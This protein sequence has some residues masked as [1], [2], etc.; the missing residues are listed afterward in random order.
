MQASLWEGAGKSLP[1]RGRWQEKPDGGSRGGFH[2]RPIHDDNCVEMVWHK[3]VLR[4]IKHLPQSPTGDSSLWEG[5]EKSLPR[6]GRWQAKPDGGS[7]GGFHIRP[8]HDDNCVEMVWHKYV[9][10]TIKHLPQLPAGDS[11]LWEGAEKSLPPR[12]RWQA[13]PDGGRGFALTL[14][15]IDLFDKKKMASRIYSTVCHFYKFS[16]C[17]IIG[18]IILVL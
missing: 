4:T 12:G 11:S 9:L 13:K 6:R 10:R 14:L 17:Y 15:Q 8:V 18:F 7:R 3:Y 16:I 1:R 2:I 5:A